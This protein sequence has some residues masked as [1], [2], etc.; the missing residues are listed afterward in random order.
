M[1]FDCLL[2]GLGL[3][4]QAMAWLPLRF[5]GL[6]AAE[7]KPTEF[8]CSFGVGGEGEGEGGGYLYEVMCISDTFIIVNVCV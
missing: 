8:L 3:P 1:F 6:V 2:L 7:D 5:G 4:E